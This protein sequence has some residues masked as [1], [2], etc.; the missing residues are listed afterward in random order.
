MCNFIIGILEV[1]L[2]FCLTFSYFAL[3]AIDPIPWNKRAWP[4]QGQQWNGQ[5]NGQKGAEAS[6]LCGLCQVTFGE[7]ATVWRQ[8]GNTHTEAQANAAAK[9]KISMVNFRL[10]QVV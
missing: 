9:L 8:P 7:Q 4:G 6:L 10:S 2:G 5:R 1:I 3:T